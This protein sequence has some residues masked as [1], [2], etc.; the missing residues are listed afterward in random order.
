MLPDDGYS[1]TSGK[2]VPAFFQSF[3]HTG[4]GRI[5]VSGHGV[6]DIS[7]NG[8]MRIRK[9]WDYLYLA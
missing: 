4:R 3:P 9:F 2:A 8:G 5:T 6:R 1:W 7:C